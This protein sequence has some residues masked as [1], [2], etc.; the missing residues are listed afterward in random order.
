[1]LK[2]LFRMDSNADYLCFDYCNLATER[3][4]KKINK[5]LRTQYTVHSTFY[6]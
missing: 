2:S 5:V 3:K 1:M 6:K 4:F